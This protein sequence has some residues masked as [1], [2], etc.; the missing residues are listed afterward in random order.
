MTK[1]YSNYSITRINNTYYQ[2]SV[3]SSFFSKDKYDHC[4]Y[5]NGIWKGLGYY[6]DESKLF[7]INFVKELNA[8][9]SV[10]ASAL[11]RRMLSDKI[12][13]VLN[14][15]NNLAITK[16]IVKYYNSYYV[17]LW[18]FKNADMGKVYHVND[19]YEIEKIT[20]TK[21]RCFVFAGKH[22]YYIFW[23]KEDDF[24][25]LIEFVRLYFLT[26]LPQLAHKREFF[27]TNDTTC[28]DIAVSKGWI[29]S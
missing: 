9:F 12:K 16:N 23:D 1:K 27:I 21:E 10:T 24:K 18:T 19:K 14:M 6:N 25:Y 28:I 11:K 26:H 13:L 5:I 22:E 29:L 20:I 17:N 8:P 3:E 4:L 7:W 15:I 2:V